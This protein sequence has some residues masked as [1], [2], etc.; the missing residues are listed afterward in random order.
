MEKIAIEKERAKRY[1][2]M[3]LFILS[4]LLIG[5]ICLFIN[6]PK[7]DMDT[8]DYTLVKVFFGIWGV[9]TFLALIFTIYEFMRIDSLAFYIDDEAIIETYEIVGVVERR[10]NLKLVTDIKLSQGVLE[11]LFSITDIGLTLGFGEDSVGKNIPYL[12]E[13]TARKIMTMLAKGRK[14]KVEIV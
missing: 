9:G 8:F 11:K 5:S 10:T 13:V 7:G 14:Q 6:I 12:T 4:V 2:G 1:L 3:Y